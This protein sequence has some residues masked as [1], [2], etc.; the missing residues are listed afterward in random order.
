MP[1][2][3]NST[4]V[5]NL[6]SELAAATGEDLETAVVSAL[7]EKLARVGRPQ[8]LAKDSD[9][10]A[11]FEKIAKMPVRDGRCPDEIIGYDAHGL[12]Q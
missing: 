11:L 6:A 1:L 4:R 12:P 9:I 8:R 3:L 7:E 10:D 5:T 2:E